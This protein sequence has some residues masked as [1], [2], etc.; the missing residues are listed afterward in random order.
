[1]FIY[2]YIYIYIYEHDLKLK[3]TMKGLYAIQPNLPTNPSVI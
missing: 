2:I 3:K 1:M